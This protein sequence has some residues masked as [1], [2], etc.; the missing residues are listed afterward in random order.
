MAS[1]CKSLHQHGELMILVL[2]RCLKEEL[3]L[4]LLLDDWWNC[5]EKSMLNE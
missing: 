5:E 1:C 4:L 2:V 3:L